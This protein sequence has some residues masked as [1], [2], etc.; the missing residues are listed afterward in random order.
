MVFDDENEPVFEIEGAMGAPP[1][2]QQP[3][4]CPQNPT[5]LAGT[6]K[7]WDL[8]K[9]EERRALLGHYDSVNSLQVVGN[10]APGRPIPNPK[11]NKPLHSA[12]HRTALFET[13]DS[14]IWVSP[15]QHMMTV[16][17]DAHVRVWNTRT[18]QQ[19]PVKILQVIFVLS[20]V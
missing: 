6:V 14:R 16:S 15:G 9:M 11:P 18:F 2:A 3:K 17:Q 20:V 4:D 12:P 10:G 19:V 7:V 1:S 5:T 13:L 8:F